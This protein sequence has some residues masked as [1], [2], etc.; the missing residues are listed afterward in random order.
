MLS[1]ILIINSWQFNFFAYLFLVVIFMQTYKL[2]VRKVKKDGA[3]TI[4]LQL[5]AGFSILLFSPLFSFNFPPNLKTYFL[6]TLSCVFYAL[7]DRSQTTIR[8]HL[9]V[10]VY[11]ILGQMSKVFLI[12]LGFLIFKEPFILNKI[13][14][15]LLILGANVYLFYKKGKICF[16]K[17]VWLSFISTL[18]FA[19]AISI[20]IGISR[21]FNLPFYI[22]F[23]LIIPSLMIA[24]VERI[25]FQELKEEFLTSQNKKYFLITG[26]SWGLLILFM[27][28]AY[29]FGKVTIITP[30]AATSTLINVLIAFIFLKERENKLK[31][32]LAAM[33]VILGVFLTVK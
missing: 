32:V 10:S 14:G 25:K 20:D 6:L 3:A 30:L 2:A 17:Y 4:L 28:R 5:I 27:L 9:P 19:L 18:M 8:K 23:T 24:L 21:Q 15:G 33:L 22:A 16:N 29:R 26:L 31:K 1:F 11:S 12:F 7:Y 13:F